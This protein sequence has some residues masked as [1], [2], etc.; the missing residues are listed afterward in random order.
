MGALEAKAVVSH[1]CEFPCETAIRSEPSL[2]EAE[3][4]VHLQGG[5][6]RAGSRRVGP[7]VSGTQNDRQSSQPIEHQG[8]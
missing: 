2:P 5:T 3:W 7:G 4:L 6:L 8:F 1:V